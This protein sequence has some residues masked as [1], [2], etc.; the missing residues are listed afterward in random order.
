MLPMVVARLMSLDRSADDYF[1]RVIEL[2]QLEPV[3]AA[4]LIAS[5]NTVEHR[6]VT[7]IKSIQDA[8]V[9]IGAR[10]VSSLVIGMSVVKVFAPTNEW[11]SS[12]WRHAVQVA[13]GAKQL[14]VVSRDQ[15]V[16][17]EQVYLAGLLHDVGRFLLFDVARDKLRHVDEADWASPTEMV[18][19]ERELVGLDHTE[20]GHKAASKWSLPAV[21]CDSILCHHSPS[22]IG[23]LGEKARKTA[24]LVR[25]SDVA[26][27]G[28]VKSGMPSLWD[29]TPEEAV[30][31]LERVRPPWFPSV[32]PSLVERL[33][34]VEEESAA[35]MVLLG[36]ASA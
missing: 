5:A 28:S 31:R 15:A 23:N 18:Q 7:E 27:F 16:D 9:R 29:A 14:A 36:L 11:E 32:T 26:M 25:M 1:D 35:A 30:A 4:R 12:L 6:G 19:A 34:S 2:V 24:E 21:I 33:S 3:Y 8:V 13:L 20:L 22:R 17:P 10:K